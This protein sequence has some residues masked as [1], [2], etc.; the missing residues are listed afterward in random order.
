MMMCEDSKFHQKKKKHEKKKHFKTFLPRADTETTYYL[1]YWRCVK[2]GWST[3][4]GICSIKKWYIYQLADW[5]TTLKPNSL[6]LLMTGEFL[7]HAFTKENE[8][9][10]MNHLAGYQLTYSRHWN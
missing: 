4:L 10:K 3:I 9:W 2:C 1:L 5:H 7:S 6:P 8:T